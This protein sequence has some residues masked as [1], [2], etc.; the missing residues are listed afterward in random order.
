MS[1]IISFAVVIIVQSH[2]ARLKAPARL[3]KITTVGISMKP[4]PLIIQ[5]T[6]FHISITHGEVSSRLD[7]YIFGSRYAE[8]FRRMT[9]WRAALF[10]IAIIRGQTL[11]VKRGP[12]I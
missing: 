3:T 11:S 5:D 2:T 6:Q 12:S 4:I 8:K 9:Y 1:Q 7:Y 10:I